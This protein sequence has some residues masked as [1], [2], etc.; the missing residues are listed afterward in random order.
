MS[1][2]ISD[3]TLH[4]MFDILLLDDLLVHHR[5]TIFTTVIL[6]KITDLQ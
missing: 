2:W 5:V 1:V 3:E 4:L 6:I